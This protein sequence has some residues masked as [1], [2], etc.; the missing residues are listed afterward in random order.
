[1][2]PVNLLV[3]DCQH[4]RL[5]YGIGG[6]RRQTGWT[7]MA[8]GSELTLQVRCASRG[9]LPKRLGACARCERRAWQAGMSCRLHR[10]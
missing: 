6:M 9:V 7:G 2:A 5:V 10:E 8:L 1:M 3:L 4:F